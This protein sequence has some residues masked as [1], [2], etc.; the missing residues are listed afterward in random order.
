MAKYFT[1]ADLRQTHGKLRKIVSDIS[2]QITAVRK[3]AAHVATEAEKLY[4]NSGMRKQE[5]KNVVK[6]HTKAH[7]DTVAKPIREGF[8]PKLKEMEGLRI[9]LEEA[10]DNLTNPIRRINALTV[11]DN[12]LAARRRAAAELIQFAGPTELEVIADAARAEGDV[13]TLAAVIARNNQLAPSKRP[14]K[15]AEVVA[16]IELPGQ[17]EVDAIF[18]ELVSLPAYALACDRAFDRMGELSGTDRIELGLAERQVEVN[19]D[20]T[21]KNLDVAERHSAP[22]VKLDDPSFSTFIK[23]DP[24]REPKDFETLAEY[25]RAGGDYSKPT[26]DDWARWGMTEDAAAGGDA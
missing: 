4:A 23:E 8:L 9:H 3:E 11:M 1:A 6:N 19:E 2:R 5:L 18:A 25:H 14:F 24:T 16:G 21:L 22:G 26:M 12:N 7:M 20:G 13:A 17:A 15:N 10:R